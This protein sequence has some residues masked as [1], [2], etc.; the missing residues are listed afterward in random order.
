IRLGQRHTGLPLQRTPRSA[1]GNGVDV[2]VLHAEAL[3]AHRATRHGPTHGQPTSH[4]LGRGGSLGPGG[5]LP[6][7]ALETRSDTTSSRTGGS[8]GCDGNST[9]RHGIADFCTE[10]SALARP[11]LPPSTLWQRQQYTIRIVLHAALWPNSQHQTLTPCPPA[12]G[13]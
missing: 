11:P 3:R 2:V 9:P 4:I 1:G 7:S 12:P 5:A 6:L 10:S 8:I 13:S